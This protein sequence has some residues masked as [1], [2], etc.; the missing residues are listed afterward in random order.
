ML[1]EKTEKV[2]VAKGKGSKVNPFSAVMK[3]NLCNISQA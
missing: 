2:K 3:K 1:A